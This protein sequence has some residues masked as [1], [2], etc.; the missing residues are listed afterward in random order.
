MRTLAVT[1]CQSFISASLLTS[2]TRILPIR[3]RFIGAV[4]TI[5]LRG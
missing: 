2:R 5:L 4:I 3:G 1:S